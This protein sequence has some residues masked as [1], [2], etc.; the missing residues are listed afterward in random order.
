MEVLTLTPHR[1]VRCH[2]LRCGRG[3]LQDAGTVRHAAEG[4]HEEDRE[5]DPAEVAEDYDAGVA[6]EAVPELVVSAI[7]GEHAEPELQGEDDV[8]GGLQ[9]GRHA[10]EGGPLRPHDGQEAA[11]SAGVHAGA[12]DEGD[13]QPVAERHHRQAD[14]ADGARPGRH[15]HEG[16]R[17]D[18]GEGGHVVGD[19]LADVVEAGE[20]VAGVVREAGDLLVPEHGDEAVAAPGG[21][22]E[23]QHAAEAAEDGERHAEAGQQGAQVAVEAARGER[24]VLACDIEVSL[25]F[26]KRF[27]LTALPVKISS[28]SS[29]RP[30][31]TS[32]KRYITRKTTPPCRRTASGR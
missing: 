3:Q 31:M 11:G 14:L 10:G 12:D 22:A 27:S 28:S 30:R 9:P 20:A 15:Q 1:A 19:D 6:D 4:E 13:Q 29:G 18:G 2:G 5:D 8:C 23:V 7:G 26:R 25:N 24:R 17:G 21:H 16:E 32:R